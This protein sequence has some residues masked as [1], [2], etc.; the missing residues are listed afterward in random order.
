MR[1]GVGEGLEMR[2]VDSTVAIRYREVNKDYMQFSES[3]LGRGVRNRETRQRTPFR[4]EKSKTE[5]RLTGRREKQQ[6]LIGDNDAVY[7]CQD[8]GPTSKL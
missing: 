1:S 3:G 5:L 8:P 4:L 6:V 2:D 7:E